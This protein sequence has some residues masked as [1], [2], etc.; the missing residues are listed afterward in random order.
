MAKFS[1]VE[2]PQASFGGRARRVWKRLT[3]SPDDVKDFRARL[4]SCTALLNAFTSSLS[5]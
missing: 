5:Q 1:V 2:S 3:W 4:T